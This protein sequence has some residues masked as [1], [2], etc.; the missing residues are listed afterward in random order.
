MK[1]KKKTDLLLFKQIKMIKNQTPLSLINLLKKV[2]KLQSTLV[3]QV[4]QRL[5]CET[6]RWS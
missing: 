1:H 5:P 6:A 2:A 3:C 4:L